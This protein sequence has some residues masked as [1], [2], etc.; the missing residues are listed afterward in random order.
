[1][2]AITTELSIIHRKRHDI[3]KMF[4]DSARRPEN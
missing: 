2:E 4:G 1:M 3:Y